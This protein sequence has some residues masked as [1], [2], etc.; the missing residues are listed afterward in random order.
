MT[1]EELLEKAKE[2]KYNASKYGDNSISLEKH[3]IIFIC[4]EEG[5]VGVI[6]DGYRI[7][8]FAV[9]RTPDQT[10]QIILALED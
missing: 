2:L 1:W 6:V 10:Y 3:G 9:D 4:N 7:I 5:K 8:W